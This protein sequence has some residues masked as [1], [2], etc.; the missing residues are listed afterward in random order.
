MG[1][2]RDVTYHVVM[3]VVRPFEALDVSVILEHIS[4]DRM[5]F[6]PSEV[7]PTEMRSTNHNV[8][9]M[10]APA[11]TNTSANTLSRAGLSWLFLEVLDTKDLAEGNSYTSCRSPGCQM[12]GMIKTVL[13]DLAARD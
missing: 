1:A 4:S 3:P 9:N 13:L 7:S 11:A 6:T 5:K 2:F 10:R 12:L 8:A